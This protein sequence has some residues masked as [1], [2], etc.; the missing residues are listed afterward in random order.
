MG[1]GEE[2]VSGNS[3]GPPA[4]APYQDQEA[5]RAGAQA[6]QAPRAGPWPHAARCPEETPPRPKCNSERAPRPGPVISFCLFSTPSVLSR[7]LP[8]RSLTVTLMMKRTGGTGG[9]PWP[10]AA[11]RKE[12]GRGLSPGSLTLA[13]AAHIQAALLQRTARPS[14]AGLG[15]TRASRTLG[16]PY[17]HPQAPLLPCRA[18]LRQLSSTLG[19]EKEQVRLLMEALL[20]K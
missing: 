1:A 7:R 18:G 15:L 2:A 12:K 16:R 6:C 19:M 3:S 10:Q 14:L 4:R 17:S 20:V 5:A 8:S 11:A 9:R 13:C